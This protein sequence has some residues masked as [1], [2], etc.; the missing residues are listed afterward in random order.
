M[1][2]AFPCRVQ[3]WLLLSLCTL[4]FGCESRSKAAKGEDP[5]P[6]SIAVA[7]KKD[8][9]REVR[10]FG[11]VDA[12]STVDVRAQVQGLVTEVHFKEGDFVKRGQLLFTV[13]TRPYSASL[14]AAQ[15]E[16]LRNRAIAE[17]MRVEA[18]R[19]NALRQEGIAS[20]RD[21]A[22]ANADAASSAAEVK[23]GQAQAASASLNVAFTRITAPMD[24]RT[25]ALL[26]YPGNLVNATD[27]QPLVV[28]RSISPVYIRFSVPQEHLSTIRE[29]LGKEPLTARV[30]P[31]GERAKTIEA[32]VTFLENTVDAST[33]TIQLKATYLNAE[34][35]LWPGSSVDVVL[36]MGKDEGA[37]V[38]PEPA[39]Q[40]S[41]SGTLVF[42]IGQDGRAS[43][44]PVNV[45]RTTETQALIAYGLEPGE[46]V[47]TDGLLR[48]RKG[49]KVAE[50]APPAKLAASTS[51]EQKRPEGL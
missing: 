49:T 34:Q 43:P 47:A 37:T 23:L 17:Q 51:S 13:D 4:S 41:Q 10:A 28:L 20:D 18:E 45:L 29:R 1:A 33:G 35:E 15:A 16:L 40:R 48:L 26:V 2:T 36:V 32:P 30:T 25:G 46:R 14:A 8:V 50:A 27:A 11:S 3:T 12:S 7:E 39:L 21:V 24:G 5:V 31:R 44:R 38:V 9:P 19:A 22:K 42:V 6:V